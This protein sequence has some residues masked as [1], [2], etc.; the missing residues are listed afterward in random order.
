M[1]IHECICEH[2]SL[3]TCILALLGNFYLAFLIHFP[4]I[5]TVTQKFDQYWPTQRVFLTSGF[6]LG[7]PMG[8]SSRT[9]QRRIRVRWKLVFSH[10]SYCEYRARHLCSL[11]LQLL[12]HGHFPPGCCSQP[13][14]FRTTAGNRALLLLSTEHCPALCDLSTACLHLCKSSLY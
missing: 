12:S 7:Q 10:L 14:P 11:R 3:C 6:W 2:R 5:P 13:L 9:V 8:S 1:R 4:P